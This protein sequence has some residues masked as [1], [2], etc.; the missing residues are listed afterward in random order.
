MARRENRNSQPGL[1]K[2]LEALLK[3]PENQVGTA[4]E[5]A[6]QDGTPKDSLRSAFFHAVAPPGCKRREGPCRWLRR[7]CAAGRWTVAAADRSGSDHGTAA[8]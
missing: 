3:Q 5:N 1:K 8:G 7:C 6:H 2:R 4:A